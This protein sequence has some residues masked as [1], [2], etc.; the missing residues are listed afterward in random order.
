MHN[1]VT[2]LGVCDYRRSLN[3]W[4][5]FID[6]LYTPLGTTSITTALSL[7][8]TLWK[9]QQH[10][11]S[12]LP[13]CCVFNSLSL[14][15]AFNSGDS[16]SSRAHV[17][18]VQRIS[19][20]WTLVFTAGLPTL[21]WTLSLANQLLHFTQLNRTQP[22]WGPRYIALGRTQQKTPFFYCYGSVR[23]HGKVFI[24]PLLTNEVA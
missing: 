21:N 18:S 17:V 15:T 3:W 10:Q 11:L 7:I 22:A 1:I 2:Y 8:S 13:A 4:I 24:E 16:S 20:K 12:L 14:A 19:C 6:H 5:G 9:S 23:F